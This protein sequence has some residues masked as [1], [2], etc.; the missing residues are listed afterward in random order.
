MRAA[1]AGAGLSRA[2]TGLRPIATSPPW[3]TCRLGGGYSQ[4]LNDAVA[5]F[6]R[7][8]AS[9]TPSRRATPRP[10]PA[11]SRPPARPPPSPSARPA[12]S[13][14]RP[15]TRTS[16]PAWTSTRRGLHHLGLEH[17]GHDRRVSVG[18]QHGN[19]A[20]G[21]GGGALSGDPPLGRRPPRWRVISGRGHR[22]RIT[23]SGPA[24]PTCCSSLAIRR[25]RSRPQAAERPALRANPGAR[26]ASEPLSD[27]LGASLIL[28][29][30]RA[31]PQGFRPFPFGGMRG[32]TAPRW[33]RREN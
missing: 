7:A 9:P 26:T 14:P 8:R 11:R 33:S 29:E 30:R 17:L 15:P 24:R 22:G 21:R 18:H 20:C 19:P 27:R 28:Q 12:R 6:D 13:T 31:G 1:G 25:A 2:S 23:A 4:A 32:V 16:D 5:G 3:P 10:M